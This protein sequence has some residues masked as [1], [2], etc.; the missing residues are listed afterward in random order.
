MRK[1][2]GLTRRDEG[3]HGSAGGLSRKDGGQKGGWPEII[4]SHRV[5]SQSRTDRGWSRELWRSN[6][7][8]SHVL[9]HS[10]AGLGYQWSTWSPQRSDIWG[11]YRGNLGL[12]WGPATNYW[13]N[14]GLT[15]GPATNCNQLKTWI[16]DVSEPLQD[17]VTVIKQ[18]THHAFPALHENYMCLGPATEGTKVWNSSYSSEARG[19]STRPSGRP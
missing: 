16:Q 5:R 6:M 4:E 2:G 17:S 1:W 13:G 14:L 18:P 12:I 10:P 3:L 8:I 9:S 19:H 15:L 7:Y 11:Y